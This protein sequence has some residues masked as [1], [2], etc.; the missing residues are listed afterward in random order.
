[1]CGKFR[2]RREKFRGKRKKFRG[3]WKWGSEDEEKGGEERWGR[4][5]WRGEKQAERR[6]RD[7]SS[8]SGSHGAYADCDVRRGIWILPRE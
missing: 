2:K 3:K 8:E 1:M 5:R 6:N 4:E 7:V